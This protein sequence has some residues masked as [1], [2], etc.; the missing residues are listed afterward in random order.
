MVDGRSA[1]GT[2]SAAARAGSATGALARLRGIEPPGCP[3]ARDE[4]FARLLPDFD[5]AWSAATV[6]SLGEDASAWVLGL[7]RGAEHA[8]QRCVYPG[9]GPR[10]YVGFRAVALHIEV[11]AAVPESQVDCALAWAAEAAR[12]AMSPVGAESLTC[13]PVFFRYQDLMVVPLSVV[14]AALVTAAADANPAAALRRMPFRA[15]PAAARCSPVYL[16]FLVGVALSE[17]S[18]DGALD[19]LHWSALEEVVKAVLGVR[20]RVPVTVGAACG[21]SLYGA[22]HE[23]LRRYQAAR[24]GRIVAGIAERGGVS[25]L[26][27]VRGAYPQRRLRLTLMRGRES[28]GACLL[29]MPLDESPEQMHARIAAWLRGRGILVTPSTLTPGGAND[30]SCGPILALPV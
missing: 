19:D 23:G 30:A 12:G 8:A 4:Y 6:E 2:G 3:V 22:A 28:L 29:Q 27:D 5:M 9:R 20:L 7:R 25:A 18:G 26:L 14:H 11:D 16:R 15:Q 17:E 21:G 1:R 13:A 24:L 10:G